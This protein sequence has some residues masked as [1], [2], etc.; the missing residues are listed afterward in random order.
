MNG[1]GLPLLRPVW[2]AGAQP[3]GVQAA[4]S[5][6]AGG[7]SAAPFD[8]LNLS[9]SV[10]D[11]PEAV[12][13]NRRRWA[14]A[15]GRPPTWLTLVHGA[16]VVELRAGDPLHIDTPADAA[17]TRDVGVV[18]Q[19]TAADC[20]PVLFTLRD[21]SAVAAAHAGWRGLAA[22]VLQAT[23]SALCDGTGA[24]PSE[25]LAWLGPCIGPTAF[26]VGPDVLAA[27]Q[28]AENPVL[29]QGAHRHFHA[30]GV[31]D[32]QA[33]W[34]ADLPALATEALY[35]AGVHHVAASGRCTVSE[36][37]AFFSHRRDARTGRMAAAIWRG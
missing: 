13:E 1:D 6:R 29:R 21:G 10:A 35:A 8:A 18:C 31:R 17:W 11:A 22:G 16:A 4:M 3:A 2:P 20:L 34:L 5:L 24:A 36:P 7:V 27:F 26:E 28:S 14:A 33:R 25:V 30:Q 15:L 12:A 32:G 23:V 9:V 19:V 37:S